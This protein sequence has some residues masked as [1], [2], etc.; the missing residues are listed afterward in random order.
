MNESERTSSGS[1][2]CYCMGGGPQ[3]SDVLRKC[4]PEETREH[5]RNSRIELLK[6]LRSLIDQRIEHLS[7]TQ[8][9]GTTVPVE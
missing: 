1:A 9:K 6:A 8:Q 5:F 4:I 2:G 7:R 3:L